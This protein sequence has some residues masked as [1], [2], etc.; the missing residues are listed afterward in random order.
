MLLLVKIIKHSTNNYSD[1]SKRNEII[2]Y[3]IFHLETMLLQS[4][5]YLNICILLICTS[6]LSAPTNRVVITDGI[7]LSSKRIMSKKYSWEIN[8]EETYKKTS[9]ESK[10]PIKPTKLIELAKE[11]VDKQF[12]AEDESLLDDEFIFQ[13]PVVGPLSKKEFISAFSS[14]KLDSL[15]PDKNI[16]IYDF[17]VDVFEPN[18]VWFTAVFQG[19][20]KSNGKDKLVVSPPQANSLIF[21]EQGKVIKYTG[22]YVM[23]KD[24]GNTGGLGGVFGLLYA[25]GQPLP[26]PEAKPYQKSWQFSLFNT[27]GS[28]YAKMT[29]KKD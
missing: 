12:G 22:G 18:R 9:Q 15:F 24:R 19:T 10:F 3:S 16:G 20:G 26:F 21:N 14:F 1:D 11:V 4:F 17:R 28:I 7:A 29:A 13:F 5:L 25:I 2:I 8:M 6:I 23:D 27:V